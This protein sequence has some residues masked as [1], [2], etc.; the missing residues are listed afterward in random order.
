MAKVVR[1]ITRLATT[2][3]R[4]AAVALSHAL[5]RMAYWS[6]T[7]AGRNT[8]ADTSGVIMRKHLGYRHCSEVIML[9]SSILKVNGV[10]G[11]RKK[12]FMRTYRN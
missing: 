4:T 6:K 1:F 8:L 10:S 12:L 7:R 11:A 9:T 3:L 2:F 5:E